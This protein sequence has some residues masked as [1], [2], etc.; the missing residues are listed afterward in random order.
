MASVQKIFLIA[1]REFLEKVQ[2]PTFIVMTF[3][4]PLFFAILMIVPIWIGTMD[5]GGN[6]RI[7]VIDDN[8]ELG[9]QLPENEHISFLYLHTGIDAAKKLVKVG[10]YDGVLYIPTQDIDKPTAITYFGEENMSLDLQKSIEWKLNS[11]F[12]KLKLKRSGIDPKIL[13]EIKTK[14]KVN[15][16]NLTDEGGEEEKN[17]AASAAAGLGAAILIYLFIF[18]YG[19]QVMRGVIEEKTNRIVE[20]IITSIKPVELMAGKISGIA[21]VA[22]LQ[23]SLWIILTLG[24]STAISSRYQVDRFSDSKLTETLAKGKTSDI[25]QAM[26]INKVISAVQSLNMPYLL[27]VFAFYFMGG[28][29][30][31]AALFA[32]IGSAVDNETDTQQ[33][34]LPVTIPLVLAFIFAQTIITSPD[35]PLAIWLSIIPFTSP[36][37][38]MVR[39]PFG[40]PWYQLAASMLVLISTIVLFS[41][42]A[43]R[44]Y[45]VGIL[46]Y[47]KKPSFKE[48][49]KWMFY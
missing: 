23:F 3:L 28:Y 18:M 33:F 9:L 29:L 30:L 8:L 22:L 47:G 34:M 13:E 21:S 35:G 41:W 38:M 48:I 42:L 6:K 36:I 45:R 24:I 32:A 14:I 16:V 27:A 37:I 25:G 49:G 17:N 26:E 31:Y 20:V 43:G 39:I 1:K 40:V 2:K 4:G 19:I 11:E 44:I 12:E 5:K 7:A 10:E 15:T 46:M